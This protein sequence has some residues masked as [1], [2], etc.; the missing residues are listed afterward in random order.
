MFVRSINQN[1]RRF[2]TTYA[3]LF[4]GKSCVVGCSGNFTFEQLLSLST[5]PAGIY[6]NDVSIYSCAI[7][8]LLT[9]QEFNIKLRPDGN[10]WL[11]PFCK[12]PID[13]LATILLLTKFIKFNPEKGMWHRRMHEHYTTR[14]AGYHSST[15]DTLL[16]ALESIRVSSFFAGDVFDHYKQHDQPDTI[17]MSFMPTYKGGYERIY[18]RLDE[19]FDWD[20]PSYEM[21]DDERRDKIYDYLTA[22]KYVIYDDRRLD[23][24]LVF[25]EH[26]SSRRNVY[27]YSNLE[28]PKT[29]VK[30]SRSMAQQHYPMIGMQDEITPKS[31]VKFLPVP[32]KVVNYYREM[33]LSKSIAYV[34]GQ[35]PLLV[36]IDGKL[37]GCAIFGLSKFGGSAKGDIYLLSDFVVTGSRYKRLSKLMLYLLTTKPIK[38]LL[39]EKFFIRVKTIHTTAFT[40]RPSSAKYRGVFKL[41]KKGEGFLNYSAPAG[42]RTIKQAMREWTDKFSKHLIS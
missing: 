19:L 41:V 37:I 2:L 42:T 14:W 35:Y 12:E 24:P 36:F 13:I 30:Q 15:K 1:C 7:G 31:R 39:E 20:K 33:F 16:K 34:D 10:E 38:Q 8:W 9:G 18:K 4:K 26:S 28:A 29:L 21:L 6:S 23:L 32:N 25:A 11:T 27:M 17:F 22:R 5:K 3:S 40:K